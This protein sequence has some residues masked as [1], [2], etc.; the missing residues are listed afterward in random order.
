M[1]NAFDER[2]S[3]HPN[4]TTA[5]ATTAAI[6][7]PALPLCRNT[8]IDSIS[9]IKLDNLF[10]HLLFIQRALASIT[11]TF[12]LLSV[13][14]ACCIVGPLFSI[15]FLLDGFLVRYHCAC[16]CL[17]HWMHCEIWINTLHHTRAILL[18]L[19]PWRSC[20]LALLLLPFAGSP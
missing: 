9:P 15:C 14:L 17:P 18:W 5:T 12:L 19:R 3:I 16:L 13:R 7:Q 6:I 4:W 8:Y 20:V 1:L 11:R 2:R 10:I